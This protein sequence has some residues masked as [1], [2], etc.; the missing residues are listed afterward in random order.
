LLRKRRQQIHERIATTLEASFPEVV[1]RQPDLIAHHFTEAG[2]VNRA[3]AYWLKAGKK[4]QAVSANVEAISHLRRG[5]T[6]LS[7]LEPSPRTRQTGTR[8]SDDTRTD[9]HGCSRMV[10]PRGG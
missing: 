3:V 8:L 9:P 2:H 10:G 5:L 7:T 4:A 6:L 1:N